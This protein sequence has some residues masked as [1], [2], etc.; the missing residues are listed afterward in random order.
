[1]EHS[2]NI[3]KLAKALAAFQAEIQDPAREGENPHFK[4][5]YVTIDALLIA[6]RPVAAKHGLSI[7]QSTGGNGQDIGVTTMILHESGEWLMTDS[8]TIRPS[9]NNPQGCMS[10][11]TYS[12]RY[13]LSAALGVAWDDD[14]DGN[15]AS[16]PDPK[17]DAKPTTQPTKTNKE[18]YLRQVQAIA[19]ERSM[20]ANDIKDV[21]KMQFKK[22]S[23]KDLTEAEAK[24]LAEHLEDYMIE[25]IDAE[26]RVEG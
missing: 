9:Q 13:S 22:S 11:I 21:I 23:S 1:M 10:A 14:D 6:V 7:V 12:R 5:K 16:A 25:L 4:S 3:G 2:E 17:T 20:S 18:Q 26:S 19:K 15:A 8:L 24:N